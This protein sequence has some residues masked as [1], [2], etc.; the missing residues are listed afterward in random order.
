MKPLILISNDDGYQSKGL[1]VLIEAM[2]P[3]GDLFVIAPDKGRSGAAASITADVP[4]SCTPIKS[5]DGLQVYACSGTPADCVKLALDQLLMR[6]PDLI[7]SGINHGSNA[8]VNIHYSGTIAVAQEGAL[9]GIPSVAFSSI[10]PDANAD[11][12]HL[13]SLCSHIAGQVLANGLPFGT[14]LNVN[15]PDTD[16]FEGVRVCRMAYSKWIDE[17]EPCLR[18]RGGRYFWLSGEN[19]DEEP[20][21]DSTDLWALSHD[22]VAIVPVKIDPTDYQLINNLQNWDL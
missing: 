16:Y 14:Y 7:V 19:V 21:N 20:N 5:E 18:G 2:R 6:E 1:E 17:F 10:N 15:F 9:H 4:V 12:S 11:L 22:Y 3:L 13:S 8:S